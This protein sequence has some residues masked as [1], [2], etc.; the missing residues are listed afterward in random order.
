LQRDLVATASHELRTPITS[1]VGY[2][3][4]VLDEADQLP[5]AHRAHLAVVQRASARLDRLVDDLLTVSRPDRDS[6]PLR[7]EAVPV[8]ELIAQ[9][10]EAFGP[11][12]AGKRLTLVVDVPAGL[13]DVHAD[14]DYT[15]RV[16]ANLAGNAV[17]FTPPGGTVRLAAAA[18][19]DGRVALQ[20]GDTGIG[21]P[22]GELPHVF[23]RFFRASTAAQLG[24][25]GSGLGLAIARQLT[26]A[27]HGTLEVRSRP[28]AGTTV[29]VTLPA[30][31]GRRAITG[32]PRGRPAPAGRRAGRP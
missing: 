29:T 8:G 31:D 27:Q 14:R 2:L 6:V 28:G 24:V 32:R 13:P 23:D 19:G 17:K 12:C 15:D 30:A 26:E 22:P 10:A 1:I 25:P 18:G 7:P 3:E 5:A 21:I 9:V 11:L 20:V 4:L 16:L